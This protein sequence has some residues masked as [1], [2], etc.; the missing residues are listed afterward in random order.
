MKI[1]GVDPGLAATG[2][3]IVTGSG[4]KVLGC[5]YGS[6]HT[7]KD[8]ALPQRLHRIYAKL[9]ALVDHEKPDLI[10]IE[11][12]FSLSRQPMS[13]ITLGQVSGVVLLAG[14]Q[15]GIPVME[16]AVREAKQ[17]LTGNGNASKS[18]L[19]MAVRRRLALVDPIR[20]YHASDALGLALIG[21]Y[22]NG[23]RHFDG[24]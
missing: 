15:A 16:I 24:R 19:E 6:I 5:S 20:P 9:A 18:Q 2:L 7:S 14:Y 21:L 4:D 10:V 22:R 17:V 1:I 12:V 13:G 11:E 3:G 8:A 23:N